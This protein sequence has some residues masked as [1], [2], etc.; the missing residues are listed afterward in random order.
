MDDNRGQVLGLATVAP[1][2]IAIAGFV[3]IL[4]Y[5]ANIAI[6]ARIAHLPN[7]VRVLMR[8]KSSWGE[9]PSPQFDHDRARHS[10][11]PSLTRF[12]HLSA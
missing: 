5:G 9:R 3:A 6:S 11:R 8:P 4:F 12:R 1:S 7:V 2:I 10:G